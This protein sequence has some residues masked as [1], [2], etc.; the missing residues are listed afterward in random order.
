MRV[1]PLLLFRCIHPKT[2]HNGFF[3]I[4]LYQ[5]IP[6]VFFSVKIHP[7]LPSSQLT[8]VT[9]FRRSPHVA[10]NQISPHPTPQPSCPERQAGLN[11]KVTLLNKKTMEGRIKGKLVNTKWASI[12]LRFVGSKC[13]MFN[14]KQQLSFHG[15]SYRFVC[16]QCTMDHWQQLSKRPALWS[17]KLCK[18]L[19]KIG[20]VPMSHH[21]SYHHGNL[22]GPP[23]CY[24][25]QEIRP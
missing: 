19:P 4:F 11:R 24:P 7:K 1:S 6:A 17:V 2:K 15:P 18:G 10:W 12:K 14:K 9:T 20:Q 25:P 13:L 21:T 8:D 16:W 5:T 23:Q 3:N 22:R